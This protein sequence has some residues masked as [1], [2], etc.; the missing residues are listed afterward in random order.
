MQFTN[1]NIISILT[2]VLV[3]SIVFYLFFLFYKKQ[4]LLNLNFKKL[5]IPK[6]FFIKYL[7]LLYS[8]F[9]LFLSLFGPRGDVQM[10]QDSKAIDI[11]FVLDV[12]KSMNVADISSDNTYTR[13]DFAK[14]AIGN[15]VINNK[16]NR[17]SLVIFSG[18]A[19]SSLPLTTDIDI[20][21][22]VLKNVDYR[23]LTSQGTNFTKALE[24]AFN[25]LDYTDN[26]S[27]AVILI[28]DGGE[29]SDLGSLEKLNY[30]DKIKVFVAGIGSEK[31]G[32]IITGTD[33][34]GRI[35]Y[36]TYL[37][38]F[39]ISKLNEENL[40]YISNLFSGN[41]IKLDSYAR[42]NDFTNYMKDIEKKVL[43]TNLSVKSD[44]SRYFSN[45]SFIFFV[46][47][48]LIYFTENKIYSLLNKRG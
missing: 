37:G 40:Q 48:L 33:V 18:D 5:S 13:L 9:I 7:F 4:S 19:V 24:L 25:R 38:E 35:N 3:I 23:N 47:F 34:F 2:F 42:I 21:L 16:E 46:I 22:G 14:E 28:S 29:D 32:K 11:V 20:F 30:D 17:Y 36:Q 43:Q 10:T 45:I 12:S 1:I 6:Y 27:G 39:V 15:F 41:Y 26:N 31:G 8:F 44:L